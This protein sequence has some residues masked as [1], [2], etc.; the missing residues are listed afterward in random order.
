M[1]KVTDK[2]VLLALVS[3]PYSDEL[4]KKSDD[5]IKAEGLGVLEEMYKGM[6]PDPSQVDVLVSRWS[7]DPFT[8]GSYSY[9]PVGATMSDYDVLT[10]PV[11]NRVFFAGEATTKYFPALVNGAYV[12]GIREANRIMVH[13]DKIY[14]PPLKQFNET[15]EQ[16]PEYVICEDGLELVARKSLD[17][18]N[19]SVACVKPATKI[20][21][22]SIGWTW[23]SKEPEQCIK[24]EPE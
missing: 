10:E 24:N 12:T 16:Y 1:H 8:R 21:L 19:K 20:K 13:D 11:E 4:D 6:V 7:Q 14:L 17:S 22:E 3:E 23:Q 9:T 2:P 15:W 5:E 18:G